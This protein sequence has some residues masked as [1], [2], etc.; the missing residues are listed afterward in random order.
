VTSPVKTVDI[1]QRGHVGMAAANQN[2]MFSHMSPGS[3]IVVLH[4]EIK[5]TISE[6]NFA[7]NRN[8]FEKKHCN[9]IDEACHELSDASFSGR[10]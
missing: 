10:G 5:F 7:I 8:I 2:E 3:G 1:A 4:S 6:L 9:F